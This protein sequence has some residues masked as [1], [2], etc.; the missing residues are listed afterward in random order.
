M[1]EC[2]KWHSFKG[3]PLRREAQ[4]LESFFIFVKLTGPL[5]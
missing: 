5:F 2:Q 1:V 3:E 4:H